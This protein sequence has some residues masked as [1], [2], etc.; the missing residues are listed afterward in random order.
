MLPPLMTTIKEQT[1]VELPEWQVGRL[2]G[3]P[4]PGPGK[5]E[6][7]IVNGAKGQ[8]VTVAAK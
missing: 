4:G 5:A 7:V 8:G 1:G 2:G 3:K 6:S